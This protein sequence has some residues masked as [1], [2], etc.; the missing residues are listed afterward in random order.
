MVPDFI[1][2][3]FAGYIFSSVF[4]ANYKPKIVNKN[5]VRRFYGKSHA[6]Y[7]SKYV[8]L[9]EATAT[10]ILSSAN[11]IDVVILPPDDDQLSKKKQIDGNDDTFP[12][13]VAGQ[14]EVH[15]YNNMGDEDDED[16]FDGEEL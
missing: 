7:V 4:S 15:E 3:V 1:F 9:S 12:V 13:D 8:R 16:L 14:I 5:N 2:I 6:Q 10:A 11:E